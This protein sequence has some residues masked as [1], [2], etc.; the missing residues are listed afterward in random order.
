[1]NNGFDTVKEIKA[2]PKIVFL[3]AI[4]YMKLSFLITSIPMSLAL[5]IEIGRWAL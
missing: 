3:E 4:E 5:I 2:L 1:M